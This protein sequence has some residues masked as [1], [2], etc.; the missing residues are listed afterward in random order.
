MGEMRNAYRIMI[1]K[2]GSR[3]NSKDIGIDGSIILEWKLGKYGGKVWTGS[4][5]L[6]M[7]TRGGLL[8]AR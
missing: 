2:P 6:R 5:W 1:G 4:I 8:W 7:S 3:D